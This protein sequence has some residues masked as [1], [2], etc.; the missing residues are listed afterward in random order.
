MWAR[1][2][3]VI[4]LLAF[5][6]AGSI[7]AVAVIDHRHKNSLSEPAFVARW[8][9]LHERRAEHCNETQP[10]EIGAAWHERE[11]FYRGGFAAASV[12]GLAAAAVA[13]GFTW[14]SRQPRR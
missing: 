11:R 6:I 7:A 2:A 10:Q 9:C 5:M 1:R 14:A 8:Y 13:V 12:G 3:I 4:G